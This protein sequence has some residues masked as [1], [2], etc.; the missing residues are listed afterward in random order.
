MIIL[1][2]GSNVGDRLKHLRTAIQFIKDLES[3]TVQHVSPVYHSQALLPENAPA[4]WEQPFLNLAIRC[5]THLDPVS[6][7]QKMKQIEMA[8]GRENTHATHWGPR[9]IDIDILAWES[10]TVK[11]PDLTIP[12]PQLTVRP[13]ALWPLA[14]LMPLWQYPVVG[15]NYGKSAAELVE[16][17][18]SRFSGDAPLQTRQINQR[19][20]TPQLVGILNIT[21]NSFSDGGLFLEPEKAY[22]QAERLVLAGASVIDIGAESTA[23][24]TVPL[25]PEEEWMRLERVLTPLVRLKQH[26]IIPPLLSVDTRHA[27]TAAKALKAG[28]DWINDVTGLEDHA[29][30]AIVAASAADCVVMHHQRIPASHLHTLPRQADNVKL[31]Y[32][33]AEHQIKQLTA[34]GIAKHR[35]IPYSHR[36]PPMSETL[37]PPSC[38]RPW[39]NTP[40]IIFVY[41]MLICAPAPFERRLPLSG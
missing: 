5:K 26:F 20:D 1:G 36:T 16:G 15:T 9:V 4:H 39:P 24:H 23:P 21:P 7:L 22:E 13:F 14:D 12:H 30:Q 6:L 27:T 33:W 40:S 11:D 41:T 32:D 28:A 31:V 25:T 18:G 29:M 8:M 38:H 3:L 34:A 19:V 37:K 10:L 17:W 2:L 35:F